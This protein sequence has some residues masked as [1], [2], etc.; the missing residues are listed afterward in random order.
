MP[1]RPDPAVARRGIGRRLAAAAVSTVGLSLVATGIGGSPRR[2]SADVVD[3][4]RRL[5]T[6]ASPGWHQPVHVG[7]PTQLVGFRWAG[8]TDGAVEVR[9]RDQGRWSSWVRVEGNP[10]EGPDRASPEFRGR[11]AAGPVW[12]GAGVHDLEVRVVE[13]RLTHLEIHALRTASHAASSGGLSAASAEPAQPV[14]ITRAQW[15]ADES[16]RNQYS[17]CSREPSYAPSVRYA[18]VHHTD[19]VNDYGPE[20]AASLIQGM[21]YFHT[22]V[23]GWCDIGYNFLVDRF[24]RAYEGRYGGID[25]AVV[26][27][28]AGGFNSASTGVALIGTFMTDRVPPVMYAALRDLLAWKL[29]LHGVNPTAQIAVTSAGF[30]GSQWAAGATVRVWTITGHRDVD[31]TDCPGDLAYADLVALRVDVQRAIATAGV[32]GAT[33]GYHLVASDGGV[34]AFGTAGFFG[35]TGAIHLNRP[36][37]GMAETPSA[38]GY[39]LVASDGG[40]FAFGDALFLGSTAGGP[41]SGPV[42]GMART[43]TGLGYWLAASD[44][45]IFAFGDARF[46][47]SAGA[48][49]LNQPIV[50]MAAT[51]DGR[52]YW[53]VA[54]DGGVFAFGDAAFHGS[55]G[56]IHLNQ[57]IV[58]MAPTASG[59]GYWFGAGDGGVFTFGDAVFSGSAGGVPLDGPM[60]SVGA[61]PAGDGYRLSSS[62]GVLYGFGPV[63]FYG[64]TAPL[65]LARPVVTMAAVPGTPAGSAVPGPP[66]P[67]PSVPGG[68]PAPPGP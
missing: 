55:T 25:K 9:V 1:G 65:T 6:T 14:I 3:H 51:R 66:V 37:V 60:V 15:G 23:N 59:Q 54:R 49:H 4:G 63:P 57:P 47:G 44:G 30:S 61:N 50:G 17:Y 34:F 5:T 16:W 56:A 10:A 19:N 68:P 20:Q 45:G 40:I 35:S 2:Q 26:G 27:A 21:Y 58:G 64:S 7:S 12:V 38:R 33:S 46:Y 8:A 41:L 22:H 53:L 67:G 18:I 39:W 24:G 11:T 52:G 31:Q 42:V 36:V 28:H 29:A 62:G 32:H 43:P 13:G 48:I